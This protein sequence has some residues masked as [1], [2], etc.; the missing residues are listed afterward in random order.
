MPAES[1]A[2]EPHHEL[3]RK[4]FCEWV[5]EKLEQ[6][7]NFIQKIFFSRSQ[8]KLYI[9]GTFPWRNCLYINPNEN[10]LLLYKFGKKWNLARNKLCFNAYLYLSGGK[11]LTQILDS[12]QLSTILLMYIFD[13]TPTKATKQTSLKKSVDTEKMMAIGL[14]QTH[15]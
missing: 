4:L 3:D 11:C 14:H 13:L 10:L 2:L 6:D 8:I 7:E 12:C 15:T 9:N 5:L 1:Q